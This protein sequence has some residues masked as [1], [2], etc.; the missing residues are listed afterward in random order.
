MY[1]ISTLSYLSYCSFTV[2]I[3]FLSGFH[4]SPGLCQKIVEEKEQDFCAFWCSLAKIFITTEQKLSFLE[5]NDLLCLTSI[6]IHCSCVSQ[7]NFK[8]T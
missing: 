8:T 7:N 4:V 3:H 6:L 1:D 5:L 2:P